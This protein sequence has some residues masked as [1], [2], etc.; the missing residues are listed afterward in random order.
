MTTK[1][2]D[3][4]KGILKDIEQERNAKRVAAS[5]LKI[6]NRKALQEL[7]D[8]GWNRVIITKNPRIILGHPDDKIEFVPSKKDVKATVIPPKKDAK[9]KEIEDLKKQ[10]KA[11]KVPKEEPEVIEE[12]E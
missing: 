8:K 9:D 1:N 6:D 11:L 2:R 5:K 10:V 3:S 12:L 7:E 4:L